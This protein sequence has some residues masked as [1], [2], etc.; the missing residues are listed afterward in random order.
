VLEDQLEAIGVMLIDIDRFKRINDT[1][2]HGIG[3][4]VLVQTAQLFQQGLRK[5]DIASRWGRGV[6]NHI[7]W[8]HCPGTVHQTAGA[9]KTGVSQ[10]PSP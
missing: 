3:D 4:Q 2:G 7:N 8:H 1:F 9:T 10:L 6:P 5:T